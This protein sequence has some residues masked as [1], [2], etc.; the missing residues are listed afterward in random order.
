MP[1]RANKQLVFGSV[2][3]RFE[4]EIVDPDDFNDQ[5]DPD[6]KTD[7]LSCLMHRLPGLPASGNITDSLICI[8]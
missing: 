3:H 4:S 6:V 5:L 2:D 8:Q 7:Y 1:R